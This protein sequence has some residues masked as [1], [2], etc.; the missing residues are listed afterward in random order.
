M[1]GI[2]G[3]F[4]LNKKFNQEDLRQMNNCLSH[5]GPDAEGFYFNEEGT[6][7]LGHRRLSII[8]LS[9]AANQPMF[10]HDGRYVIV[11]NG[12]VYNFQEVA[13]QLNIQPRTHS[14]TEI[15]LEAFALKG[16]E[17]VQYFN[18]MFA[19]AIYDKAERKLTLLRDRL[20]VKP[21]CYFYDGENLAF[22]SEIK[23]LLTSQFVSANI[24]MNKKTVYSFLYA[25]YIPEPYT[26]YNNIQRLPAGSYATIDGAGMKIQSYWQ[27]E[28]KVKTSVNGDFNSA[29]NE[30]KE[31]LTSSVRYRMISDV[32]FGTFL[33]GGVDSSTVTAIAQSISSQPVKTFSIG[34]KD[35]KFNE[36]QYARMVSDHLKTDHHEFIVTEKDALELI[37]QM[38]TAYDEPYADSSAIPTMLVSKL[39]RKH[40]TMTLSGDGGDELFFGYGAY[41]W[42]KRL[43]NTKI[44]MARQLISMALSQAGNRYK[45]AAGVFDYKSEAHKKSH[46]FS[47]EQYFFSEEELGGLLKDDYLSEPLFNEEFKVARKLTAAEEQALFDMKYYLKDDLLVKVDIASMQFALETRTPFLDYRIVEFALNLAPELKKQNGI[48]KYILKEVL[49]DYVPRKIFDRPKWGFSVPMARWLKTDLNYLLHDYLNEAVIAQVNI[50]NPAVV[51]K[52]I[53]RFVAGEDFLFNR[54]WVLI[55]LHK[56]RKEHGAIN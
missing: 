39:A 31:L 55:L 46:I 53:I 42:A 17:C 22:G 7:G 20:G 2:S 34:F 32:P 23:S 27:P 45:R 38:M 25:G 43:D 9:A 3:Y 5:R 19:I 6:V 48:S 49:Y 16:P 12:E 11:F 8:D 51:K 33:S 35:A 56:W 41:D 26:I 36:S 10:S 54:I 50:V 28:E 30:L 21:I 29:K 14:D 13:K 44:K 15:I 37:D 18:G 4:S 1:C 40:V 24:Q 47:Q 52:L